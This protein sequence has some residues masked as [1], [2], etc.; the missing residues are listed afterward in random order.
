MTQATTIDEVIEILED[1]ISASEH[2]NSPLGFFAILYL[3]VTK[4]VKEGIDQQFFDDNSRMEKLDVIFANRYLAA[5]FAYQ[6]KE[7]LSYCWRKAFEAADSYWP[8]TLQHLLLGINAHI[9]LDLG[10]AAA[11]VSAG[12][13]ITDLKNDFDKIN[14]ILAA[15]VN[16]VQNDLAT[17]W[18]T[19]AKILRWTKKLDDH[20]INFSM[21]LVRNDAWKLA[22]LLSGDN[23]DDIPSAIEARDL[24]VTRYADVINSPGFVPKIVLGVVRLGERGS[25][26][27]KIRLLRD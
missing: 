25:V 5:Y 22:V 24:I 7:N 18:P 16:D 17:I 9:S 11:E 21:E 14:Q 13:P 19:L 26:A 10:V 15:L 3:K 1:I 20:L 2:N 6:Q 27:E 4:K 12:Q 8:I 23:S